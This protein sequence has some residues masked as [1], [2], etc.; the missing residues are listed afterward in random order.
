MMAMA[1][2]GILV[3]GAAVLRVRRGSSL[4]ER[5]VSWHL[6]EDVLGGD[7]RARGRGDH[8]PLGPARD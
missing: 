1:V 7:R 6:L 2:V 4:T 3:N 5:V 8:G